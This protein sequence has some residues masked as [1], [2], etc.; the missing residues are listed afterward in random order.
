MTERIE[1]RGVAELVGAGLEV[2]LDVVESTGA[3]AEVDA[4]EGAAAERAPETIEEIWREP[5]AA[6]RARAVDF[7]VATEALARLAARASR[8]GEPPAEARMREVVERYLA[9]RLEVAAGVARIS[10]G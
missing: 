7:G 5:P 4:A 2:E 10:I 6:H 9:L 8:P 3:F 1:R